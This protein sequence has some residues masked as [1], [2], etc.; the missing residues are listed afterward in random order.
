MKQGI[1]KTASIAMAKALAKSTILK[2]KTVTYT[3]TKFIV[4]KEFMKFVA[5]D[6]MF[7]GV[8]ITVGIASGAAGILSF[9]HQLYFSSTVPLTEEQVEALLNKINTEQTENL[10]AIVKNEVDQ[11]L[12]T[13][14]IDHH[15]RITE[16]EKQIKSLRNQRNTMIVA[17]CAVVL[18]AAFG[19][20][21]GFEILAERIAH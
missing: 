3:K 4:T 15:E 5:T 21:K 14:D 19:K 20:T 16:S 6:P 10:K 9:G 18:F 12:E 11:K 8:G 17:L 13:W 2:Q 1:T 7:Q